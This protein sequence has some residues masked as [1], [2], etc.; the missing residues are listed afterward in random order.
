MQLVPII[1]Q[2]KF[3]AE[4]SMEVTG[5]AALKPAKPVQER[6]LP[7]LLSYVHQQLPGTAGEIY[8]HEKRKVTQLQERRLVCR[9]VKHTA[10]LEELRSVVDRRRRK[11]RKSDIQLHIDEEA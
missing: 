5:I 3:V 4:D 8:Q 9:R 11:Q 1:P 6:T 10:I 2:Q 7:P